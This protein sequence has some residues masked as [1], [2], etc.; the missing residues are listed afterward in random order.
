MSKLLVHKIIGF[1]FRPFQKENI[2]FFFLMYLLGLTSIIFELWNGSR[3]WMTFELFFDLYI[4]SLFVFLFFCFLINIDITLG[5]YQFL[6]FIF[7]LL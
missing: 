3:F 5:L 1:L 7:Y 6:F 2:L 4:Y